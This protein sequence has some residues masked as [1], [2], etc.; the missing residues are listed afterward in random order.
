MPFTFHCFGHKNILA[1][2]RNTIEF[3]KESHLT[4]NGDCILGVK[5]DFDFKELIEFIKKSKGKK[6]K[7]KIIVGD[8]KDEFS[9]FPNPSFSHPEEMVIRKTDFKSERTLGILCDKSAKDIKRE[10]INKMKEHKTKMEVI[11]EEENLKSS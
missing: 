11:Y 9:F 4:K 5:A 2:H 3:T 7:A 10:I 6:I 1:L 8:Y